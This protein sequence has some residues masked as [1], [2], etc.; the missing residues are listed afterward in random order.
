M[1]KEILLEYFKTIEELYG[2]H[3]QA[4]Q[5]ILN[6]TKK[7]HSAKEFYL[8]S[9]KKDVQKETGFS[10]D[11]LKKHIYWMWKKLPNSEKSQWK[12]KMK[13]PKKRIRTQEFHPHIDSGD[14]V[15]VYRKISDKGEEWS[16]SCGRTRCEHI[17]RCQEEVQAPPS[18]TA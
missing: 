3:V 8:K 10:G 2:I 17:Q 6:D 18:W 11:I 14:D 12:T 7:K 13:A 4:Q 16:C 15:V 5:K 9:V 1:S